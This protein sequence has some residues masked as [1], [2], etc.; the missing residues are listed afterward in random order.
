MN[1]QRRR[2]KAVLLALGI[3][4]LVVLGPCLL[5]AN[6]VGVYPSN[7]EFR[8]VVRGGEYFRTIGIINNGQSDRVF[9]LTS[10]GPAGQ[11]L[12]FVDEDDRTTLVESV[13]VT[14]GESAN[15]MLRLL[16]ATDAPNDLYQGVVRVLSTPGT[17]EEGTSGA[18][19]SIGAEIAIAISV[20]GE[21]RLNGQLT[22]LAVRD[23]EVGLPLRILAT[24]AN[25][26]NVQLRPQ[27]TLQLQKENSI[28]QVAFPAEQVVYPGETRTLELEWDTTGQAIGKY[29]GQAYLRTG[30]YEIGRKQLSFEIFEWG[31]FQRQGEL[32]KLTLADAETM[33][34]RPNDMAR[35]LADFKNTG[36]IDTRAKFIG[37][38]HQGERLIDV[39]TSEELIV[40]VGHTVRLESFLKLPEKGE[41]T[42]VG[43]VNYEGKETDEKR[44]TFLVE[45][46]PRSFPLTYV[47]A[48]AAGAA[49]LLM[50]GTAVVATRMLRKR[51]HG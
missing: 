21:Q 3:V 50:G 14:A 45:P 9:H 5:Y 35:I 36:Q 23:T 10:D 13:S 30:E 26:G 51:V 34:I 6:G 32:V 43:K 1:G 28:N 11:W 38:V 8:D 19:I 29:V 27:L 17:V 37:Q 2:R 42:L 20:I 40:P 25:T 18:G 4:L 24:V 41:Y 16:V 7:I 12:S 31:H 15:V 49:G 33:V 48:I 44:I 46:K 39:I 47:I 22:D